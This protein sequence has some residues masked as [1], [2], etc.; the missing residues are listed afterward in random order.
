M[1]KFL[2]FMVLFLCLGFT[3]KYKDD[4]ANFI[5]KNFSEEEYVVFGEPNSYFK[6]YDYGFVQNTDNLYPSNRNDILNIIY[7]TL[8]RGVDE[9]TFYC[10]DG[11]NECIHDVNDIA[12]DS[13]SLAT[14]NNFVHPFNSYSNIYFTITNYGKVSIKVTKTYSDSEMVLIS[15]KIKD[16]ADS[17]FDDSMSDYDKILAFHDYIVNNTVYDSSV[18]FENQEHSSTNSNNAVGLLFNGKAICSG[19]S[20]TM[21][22][23][24][25]M[26]GYNNYKISSD[27]HIWN[28]LLFDGNWVHID[29]TW[30]DPVTTNGENV[31]LHDFFMVNSDELFSKDNALE[32]NNHNYDS[33][34]Y[35]EAN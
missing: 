23:F 15:N 19:Y 21:A 4:I 14:I 6:N 33:S 31:L 10:A 34:L 16:I 1:K 13:L 9:V 8:N 24:L 18:D 22:I 28:L 35:I 3:L 5:L 2:F 29:A 7:S 25:S 17:I 26:Y 30:D 12:E 32:K 27:Q 20:D 11:Y